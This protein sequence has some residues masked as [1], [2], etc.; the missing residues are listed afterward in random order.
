MEEIKKAME[1]TKLSITSTYSNYESEGTMLRKLFGD[2]RRQFEESYNNNINKLAFI[3]SR[4]AIMKPYGDYFS[5]FC[6]TNATIVNFSQV[7]PSLVI[8]SVSTLVALPAIYGMSQL[9]YN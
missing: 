1:R 8:G 5:R 2:C 6:D 7:H 9:F 4:E 3:P